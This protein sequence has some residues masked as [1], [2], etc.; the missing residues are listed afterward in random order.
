MSTACQPSDNQ[1]LPQDRLGKDRIDKDS[2]GED[3]EESGEDMF[4]E[5]KPQENPQGK[6]DK[7][8]SE[9]I[10]ARERI[11]SLYNEICT[12][13]IKATALNRERS[14]QIDRLLLSYSEQQ[15]AQVFRKANASSYLQ[16][17]GRDAFRGSIDWLTKEKN[18]IKV[19][20]G[21]YDSNRS[22]GGSYECSYDLD[23]LERMSMFD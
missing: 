16:G 5:K 14:E 7:K 23:A 11:F 8:D 3:R 9:R 15:I 22:G 20:E 13:L 6:A 2:R 19:M 21:N 12:S 18:F 10:Y 4:T 1:W 17:R